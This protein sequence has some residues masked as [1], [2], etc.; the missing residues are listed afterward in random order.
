MKLVWIKATTMTPTKNPII[1]PIVVSPRFALRLPEQHNTTLQNSLVKPELQ[2]S[3][4][5][6]PARA[7]KII[8]SARC[9]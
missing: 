6:Q 4:A 8:S 2:N 5:P 3:F 7:S 1:R 9:L